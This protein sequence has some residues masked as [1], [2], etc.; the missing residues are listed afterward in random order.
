MR[1]DVLKLLNYFLICFESL[2][3]AYLSG[4]FFQR[5]Y[6]KVVYILA[7]CVLAVLSILL[8]SIL[9]ESF[10]LKLIL[11]ICFPMLWMLFAFRV[12]LVKALF[13][14]ALLLSYWSLADSL[15]LMCSSILLG[16]S[17]L[18]ISE[19]PYAYYLLCFGAKITELLGIS[20]I[21]MFA[22]KRFQCSPTFGSDWLLTLFYPISALLIS[23]IL[24]HIFNKNP[25][26]ARE[27]LL[28]TGILLCTDV[29]AIFLLNYLEKQQLA[30]RDN[31]IL[32]QDLKNERESISAW[33][34]AYREERKRSHDFQNQLSVLRGLV[35]NRAPTEQQLQYFDSLLN[36]ELPTTRYINANR[37]VADVLLSQKAAIAKNKGI[38]FQM[39]LDDLSLFPLPD[40]ELVV[41][42][43]NLLDNAIEACEMIPN[44]KQKYIRIKI[45]C[46]PEVSYFY[47][48]NSTAK[49]VKI[50]NNQVISSKKESAAHGFGLQNVTTI[51]SRH[52]AIYVL[53]Y[54]ETDGLFCFS[55]QI[56]SN[57]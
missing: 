35:E 30:I 2:M 53:D 7:V 37:L 41:V 24:L 9:E 52:Q 50:K 15:F 28:C 26:L 34:S 18:Q 44:E 47:I 8:I 19:S 55:A 38:A 33:I 43:A 27:L 25:N 49:P 29:L 22:K 20:I 45:Q 39:Q 1:I 57:P 13:C 10:I 12:S 32:Q 14:A 17:I 51:L 3:T 36:V 42:M 6:S 11:G 21:G 5:R 54:Q 23:I 31:A 46:K 16:Y 40:D 48:E 56:L 4:C